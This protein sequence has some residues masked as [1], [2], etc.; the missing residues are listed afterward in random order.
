MIT[1]ALQAQNAQIDSLKQIVKTGLRDT[2]MVSTL[3]DLSIAILQNEDIAESLVYSK[4]AN[5]LATELGYTKGMAYAQKNMGLAEYYQGNN[6]EVMDHWTR[7]LETFETIRDTIGIATLVNNLGAVYYSQGSHTRALEY[8]LRSLSLSE[9]TKDPLSIAKA[10][11]N[12]GGLYSEMQDYE[13][14]LEFF[15][16]IEK[17]RNDIKNSDVITSY[18]MG[19]GEVYFEQGFY[20][21]AAKYYEEALAGSQNIILRA[22]NLIKLG[23]VEFKK[24]KKQKAIDYLDEAYSIA[25]ENNQ[26]SEVIQALIALGQVYTG[27]NQTKSISAFKEAESLAKIIEANDE[28]RDI[29]QGLSKTYSGKGDYGN[30]FKYQT[31]YL[32]KKDSLF[33]LATDDKIR[34]LQFDFDLEKK[35]DENDQLVQ[36]AEISELKA[37]RQ[38]YVIIGSIL[39]L[40]L[41]FV[42]AIGSYRR[43]RYVKKTN[44]I[45]EV[46]KERSDKLLL[47]ILPEETAQE[48]KEHGKVAAKKFESVTILFSDFKGFTSYAQNLSPEILVKSVDYYFS[49]F[50]Q[51]MDKYGLEKI[52]TVGDAYMCAGG[53]PF[54]TTD[55]P[56][57]MV[58][59]A[60]EI[61]KVMED[62]KKNPI[63]DIV[64]F[65]VRI[66][67]NTGPIV[68]GVV[69]LNKFA[70]DIWGDSVNVASRMESMSEPGRINISENTYQIIK[71]VYEC[72]SRGAVHVKNKGDMKMYYVNRTKIIRHPKSKSEVKV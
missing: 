51:I 36:E 30:A 9:K 49:K 63:E 54:P 43:Y 29:Y 18:L 59:A 60:F 6:L 34:G 38:K 2:A 3:N 13:K 68:A 15:N 55:H 16:K 22:D 65:E 47:N 40:V 1:G 67:I 12:L 52:K 57:K 41:V 53:L 46:E 61:A 64:P 14:A 17:Y 20:D 33:N 45:I 42:L 50:D 27:D 24:G 44:K 32:A 10:L 5:E 4:Q 39:A 31:L 69:G 25:K 56:F 70:Y 8:Y 28:L 35:Q 66:G 72:E 23:V 37:K 19:V 11:G 58:E 71:D 48:L 7:S 26:Q 21:D 62:L